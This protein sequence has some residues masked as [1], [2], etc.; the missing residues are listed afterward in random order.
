MERGGGGEGGMYKW[1]NPP[2]CIMQIKIRRVKVKTLEHTCVK[3]P[4]LQITALFRFL[5]SCMKIKKLVMDEGS[6]ISV[7]K[8]TSKR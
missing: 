8:K 4:T 7:Y 1:N 3:W 5:G 6:F 2:E